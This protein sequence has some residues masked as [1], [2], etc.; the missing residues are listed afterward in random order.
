MNLDKEQHLDEQQLIQAV[1]DETDLPRSGQSH[2]VSCHQCRSSKESLEQELV[3]LGQIAKDYT[4]QP[5]KRIRIPVHE[6]RSTRWTFLNWR[7]AVGAAATVAAVLLVFWAT[8]SVRNLNEFGTA[9]AP[10]ELMEAKRLMM[11][12]DMLVENALPP[13]Y[14]EITAEYKPDYDKEFYQFLIPQIKT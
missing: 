1:V 3:R 14:L 12:V 7:N 6:P 2:L 8:T 5:Q 9:G 13:L 10:S 4:P 11:E